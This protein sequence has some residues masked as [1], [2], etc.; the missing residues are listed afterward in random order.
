MQRYRPSANVLDTLSP[1]RKA[2]ILNWLLSIM[3]QPVAQAIAELESP[4]A[5]AHGASLLPREDTAVA[6]SAGTVT[7][8]NCGHPITLELQMQATTQVA[9]GEV[10]RQ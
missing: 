1:E 9:K 7:C 6:Q 4:V 2:T 5:E 8:P 10:P 3:P